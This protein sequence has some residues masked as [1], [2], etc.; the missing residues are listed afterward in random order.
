MFL[1][2]QSVPTL[3]SLRG[4]KER[5]EREM[6]GGRE[7]GREGGRKEEEEV[8]ERVVR[9]LF[10]GGGEGALIIVR[11]KEEVET[12]GERGARC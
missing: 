4:K 8:V 3:L 5:E 10:L 6:E 11:E 7:D 12:E 9:V 1:Y 2:H